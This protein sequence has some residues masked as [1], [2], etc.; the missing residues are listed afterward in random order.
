M[1]TLVNDKRKR[2]LTSPRTILSLG[3]VVMAALLAANIFFALAPHSKQR[4]AQA[5]SSFSFSAVG[6]YGQSTNTTSNLSYI[7]H[8][9][10]S[11]NLGLGDFNY[12]SKV[13]T[14]AWASY[15][16]SYLP[17]NFPFEIV[18]GDH[19]R[20]QI[21]ALAADLPNHMSNMSGTYAKEYF[22]DYPATSPL[23]RFIMISPVSLPGS[24]RKGGADYNWVSQQINGARAANIPWVV[25]VMAQGCIYINSTSNSKACATPDLLNLLVSDKV[26]L[27]LQAHQHN[28]EAGKQL[29]LN[30]KTCVSI[31]TTTYNANCVAN[32]G[33]N[34]NKGAGTTFVTTGTGGQSLV[35]IDTSDPKI[36]YFRKWMGSNL[37]PTY[38]V[39]RFTVSATKLSMQFVPVTGSFSDS[40]SIS[41]TGSSGPNPRRS[42]TRAVSSLNMLAWLQPLARPKHIG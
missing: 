2:S 37:N 12:S 18:S 16:K 1:S 6:D 31:S 14:A 13:T 4:T 41:G 35:D 34:M 11:F 38:G 20:S 15:A 27:I 5:T 25:V 29:A 8:A 19:D 21:N 10:I 24:Y 3:T 40:L 39:S 30:S 32:A 23:A 22:F 42:P 9:G 7:A 26:D 33:S 36:N 17:A 28:Y